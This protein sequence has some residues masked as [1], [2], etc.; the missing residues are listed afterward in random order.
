MSKESFKRCA[1]PV[2]MLF[3]FG[4]LMGCSPAPKEEADHA[5]MI[6]EALNLMKTTVEGLG[7]ASLVDNAL[8]FGTT[9]IDG[10]N[11]TVN[12]LKDQYGCTAT[13][14]AKQGDAFVRVS[15]TILQDGVPAVGTPLDPNGPVM[16]ALQSGEPFYGTV[17]ILGKQYEAGYE[18]IKN[19]AGEVIGAMY[20]GFEIQK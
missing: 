14:F 2:V 3:V 18:P 4:L 16:K 20:A 15:T 9:A 19:A 7:E 13:F 6:K 5:A 8:M 17:D 11:Q 10:N 12:L 1:G